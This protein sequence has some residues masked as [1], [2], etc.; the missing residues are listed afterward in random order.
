MFRYLRG[1]SCI[2]GR[3]SAT[4]LAQ[5][6]ALLLL[7]AVSAWAK[8]VP[9][10]GVLVYP[11]AT[12]YSYVQVSGFLVNGKTELR[13]CPRPG[14]VDKSSYKNLA[15]I[16]LAN[17]STLERMPD[18]TLMAEV[19][20]AAAVCVIPGNIKFEK[21]GAMSLS[22]AV[23]RSAYAGQVV[24]SMP[25]GVA[26]LP[27]LAPGSKFFFGSATDPELAAYLVADRTKSIAEW[28]NYL[29]KFPVA[30]H[31][32]TAK[33]SLVALLV[34]DGTLRLS[35]Y[36][37]SATSPAPD[38]AS[39]KTARERADQALLVVPDDAPAKQLRDSTRASMTKIADQ[40]AT[41]LQG[42]KD[43]SAGHTRGYTLLVQAKDLSDRLTEVDSKFAPGMTVRVNVA[44][45][46]AAFEG[47][48]QAANTQRSAGQFD[49]AY[50]AVARYVSFAP[51]EPRIGA[52]VH[53]DYKFHMD[54][55]TEEI[56]AANWDAALV[57][58]H[59]AV[60][61]D[62]TAESKAALATADA[63][64]TTAKNKLAA[65][66]ARTRS[67]SYF[68][69]QDTIDA[70]EVLANLTEPQRLLV[71]DEMTALQPAYIV[72]TMQ[73]A[74]DLQA[75][76]SPIH[77]RADE[78]AVRQAYDYLQ[79]ASKLSDNPDIAI[80]LDLIA[81]EISAYYADLGTQYLNRPLSSGVGLGWAYLT[82]AQQYRPNLDAIRDN[83][84]R[85][86]A[87]YQMRAKLSIGVVFRD[88][89]SRR[90]SAGFADQLQQAF[91]TGLETSGL[92]VKVVLPGTSGALEPNFQFVGEIL[93]HRT[94]RTS[95]KDT[96]QSEYRSGSREN[97]SD[98]W[99][100]ADQEYE[101]TN[102]ELQKAQSALNAAQAK[103]N[104]KAVEEATKNVDATEV[105]VQQARSKMN[106]I[107]KTITESVVSPYNYTKTV[108]ELTNIVE[109]SFRIIDANGTVIGE[110]TRVVKGEKPKQFTIL[111][112]I[113]PDDTKGLKEIDSPPDETQLMTD[114][115]IEARD[116]MVKA[117][118]EQVQ[119]LPQRVLT[120]ARARVA[121]NDIDGAGELYILYLNSTV[122]KET[123]ERLEA[124]HFLTQNFNLRRAVELSASAQ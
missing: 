89:T 43:A 21:D 105:T 74:N 6:V 35:A 67:R 91:A 71:Q 122:A 117:A 65:D 18:G 8:D 33:T 16:N 100:K 115:E 20:G 19:S 95:K 36:A 52:I 10:T 49:D 81:G 102:L 78:D 87:A 114:V 22:D 26:A 110:P 120:Q 51:E 80:K 40:A 68:E 30:P 75:A 64:L 46:T 79:R 59:R 56:A 85:N 58:L 94:I 70:Y 37:K 29:G 109:L 73:K 88:Q 2:G 66:Q 11:S 69:D 111:E 50:N 15:K 9:I 98:A 118:Q 3:S 42:F 32:G 86:N 1:V 90:D 41:K 47:A 25:A 82:E 63:G 99:N 39:L 112:N 55:G 13:T 119:A 107:P 28:N 53:D 14:G 83:R 62:P 12:G 93:Q 38:Y 116:S 101:A 7:I 97:P 108:V 96:L 45:E 48:I 72:S 104:K 77:G 27:P 113:K 44:N 31:A 54:K 4:R 5:G 24:G 103:N 76:H 123:P 17:V 34:Q 92:P 106:A 61:I 60:E 124:A 84:T 23:E 57:D 121:G